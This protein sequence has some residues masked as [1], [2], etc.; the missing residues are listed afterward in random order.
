MYRHWP[1]YLD[2][3]GE[4]RMQQMNER[5]AGPSSSLGQS[6]NRAYKRPKEIL[7]FGELHAN[8]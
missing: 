1:K 3:L 6:I 2:E 4:Q 8:V 7:W 5:N